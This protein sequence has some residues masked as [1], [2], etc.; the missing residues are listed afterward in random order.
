MKDKKTI[1]ENVIQNMKDTADPICGAVFEKEVETDFATFCAFVLTQWDNI[2]MKTSKG[3]NSTL[4]LFYNGEL[5]MNHVASYIINIPLY[6][7]PHGAFGGSRIGSENKYN[8]TGN[9]YV[10]NA[11]QV[12]GL[13]A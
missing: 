5:G 6:K 2:T 13:T 3:I 12:R 9:S 4:Y 7:K 11:F 8:E 1:I 10:E